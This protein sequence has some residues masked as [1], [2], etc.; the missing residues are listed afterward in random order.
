MEE[1]KKNKSRL[2]IFYHVL[3]AFA[4]IF[5]VAGIVV[6]VLGSTNDWN[7]EWIPICVICF[8]LGIVCLLIGFTPEIN[9]AVIKTSR[10]ILDETKEDLKDI[11]DISADVSKDAVKTVA[12]AV[13]DGIDEEKTFCKHCGKEIDKGSKFCQY[14]GKEQ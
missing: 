13:K 10:H 4:L 8:I 5:I 11:A 2:P 12:R 7:F 3:K 9:K 1:K 14:C 6:T